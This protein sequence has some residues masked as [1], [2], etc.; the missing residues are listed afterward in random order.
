M[1]FINMI[2]RALYAVLALLYVHVYL[3]VSLCFRL[4]IGDQ[5]NGID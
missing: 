4:G 1:V 5:L 3:R 2:T